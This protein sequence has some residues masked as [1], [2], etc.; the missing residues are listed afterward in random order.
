MRK[1]FAVGLLI[2]SIY[3]ITIG[4]SGILKSLN[5]GNTAL[6]MQGITQ[7]KLETTILEYYKAKIAV[8]LDELSPQMIKTVIGDIDDDGDDDVIATV[9]SPSTC[10]SGGCIAS[11]FLTGDLGELSVI[12]FSY[13][14]TEIQILDS[15]TKGM[16]DLRINND[17]QNKMIWNGTSYEPERI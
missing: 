3:Y 16:H 12:P 9:E 13:A 2:F 14:I 8:T 4:A 7:G 6:L 1:L 11:I 15:I 10:G 5:L 17:E